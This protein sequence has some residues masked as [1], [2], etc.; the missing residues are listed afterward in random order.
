[1]RNWIVNFLGSMYPTRESIETRK[2]ALN[3]FFDCCRLS[4]DLSSLEASL[5]YCQDLEAFEII[6]RNSRKLYKNLSRSERL[7][8]GAQTVSPWNTADVYMA[9]SGLSIPELAVVQF[10][11]RVDVSALHL[12]AK[13]FRG[14]DD[15]MEGWSQIGVGI[16]QNGADLFSVGR[17]GTRFLTP[18]L[19]IVYCY[20]PF[21][22]PSSAHTRHPLQ[23]WNKMLRRANVDLEWYCARRS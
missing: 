6:F 13:A 10:P 17:S 16:I 2:A 3:L 19:Q 22:S 23:K 4:M 7:Q 8:I 15:N 11:G 9:K 1:M 21:D 5:C 20:H 12:V 18:F 14:R